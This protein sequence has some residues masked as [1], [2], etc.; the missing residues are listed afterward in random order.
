MPRN[1]DPSFVDNLTPNFA[2]LFLDRVAKSSGREAYRFPVGDTWE[3][4]TWQQAGDRVTHLA[5]GLLSLGIKPEQRVGHRVVDP[6]RVDPRRPR[7]HVRR[8]RHD[9][10]LPVDQHRGHGLHPQRLRVPGG[11][12]RG[13]R[14]DRQA[15]RAA[16]RDPVRHQGR[17]L[18]RHRRRRLGHHPRRAGRPRREAPRRAPRRD[19][20]DGRGHQARP[21]GHPDL[22]LRHHRPAQGRPAPAPVV[23]LRGRGDRRRRASSTRTTCSSCGCRWRTRSA[24]CCSPPSSPAAS[25]PRSTVGSRRSSTTSAW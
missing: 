23:G 5:A 8:R 22:H 15:Q 11:L 24:R 3:S 18:R 21:A 1:V 17:H 2:Q 9:D 6:L 14:A 16:Q 7:D 12:R 10:G 19:Q 25:R 4:V 13:R 20:D